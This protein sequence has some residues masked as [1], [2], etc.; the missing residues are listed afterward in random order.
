MELSS[1]EARSGVDAFR[2][3]E[4]TASMAPCTR[5]TC[6]GEPEIF[7][8]NSVPV[9]YCASLAF[10][11][12]IS[13]AVYWFMLAMIWS[14]AKLTLTPTV[15]L[16][17]HCSTLSHSCPSVR[18]HPTMPRGLSPP[19]IASGAPVVDSAVSG[20]IWVC[21]KTRSGLPPENAH[22]GKMKPTHGF[23][24]PRAPTL[25]RA[26]LGFDR[27]RHFPQRRQRFLRPAGEGEGTAG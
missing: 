11:D 17:C 3:S 1:S 23:R 25:D 12:A 19:V 5:A 27:A 15:D 24:D 8:C 16:Q 20:G 10:S 14:P 21:C 7:S 26:N 22:H 9:G 18:L 6:W 13:T 2:C 4:A